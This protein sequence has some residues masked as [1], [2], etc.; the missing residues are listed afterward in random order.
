MHV[1]VDASKHTPQSLKNVLS[2]MYSKEDI[3]FA[4]LKVN[5]ARIDSYCQ[6]VDEP[7][8]EEI[9]KLPSG[10]SMDQLK[11]RWYQ[12]RDG[13]DYASGVILPYLQSLRLKDMVIASPDVGGSKR[14]NTYAKYFGCPLVLCNKTRARA[15]VVASMQIIGDVKDKNV[16][17]IDDMVDTAGTITKAA[18]IMKQAGAK[19]VRACASHCVMSGPASERVQDSAL[20]EIVFTDSI[21]YTKR[22]AKVKQISIADMFAETIRRVEDNESISS[23]YLV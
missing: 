11:D 18:D 19:T 15:N 4:A 21:P 14:A 10:A 9:R 16:V 17:I 1:H 23:Q 3:L 5:P 7:I 8:L 6:A 20:E 2:I 22:C 13:S 12:G